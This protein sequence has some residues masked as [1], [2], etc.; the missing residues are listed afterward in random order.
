MD[1]NKPDYI[2][3]MNKILK[4]DS[5]NSD[6]KITPAIDLLT[7]DVKQLIAKY[8]ANSKFNDFLYKNEDCHS[9]FKEKY[10]NHFQDR[11]VFVTEL[12]KIEQQLIDF[13]VETFHNKNCVINLSNTKFN[14][15]VQNLFGKIIHEPTRQFDG[16]IVPHTVS[17][18]EISE[19]MQSI[20][21][22]V[23]IPNNK[24]NSHLYNIDKIFI[25]E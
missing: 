22:W 5:I 2:E 8:N 14:R 23:E 12:R 13:V 16:R 4:N 15:N 20:A 11:F 7:D 17:F 21:L 24:F 3:L 6:T 25:L 10:C 18:R 1:P 9:L 19:N